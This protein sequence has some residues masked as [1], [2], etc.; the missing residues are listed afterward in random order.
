MLNTNLFGGINGIAVECK[1]LLA[2]SGIGDE[3][4]NFGSRIRLQECLWSPKLP[5]RTP[6]LADF[7]AV[8]TLEIL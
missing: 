2:H 3:E 5:A 1:A 4:Q 6:M 7:F 8:G